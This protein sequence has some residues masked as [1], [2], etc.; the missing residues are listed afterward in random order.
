MKRSQCMMPLLA[1]AVV[2]LMA[3]TAG[4]AQGNPK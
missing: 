1:F 4:N 3:G 2:S